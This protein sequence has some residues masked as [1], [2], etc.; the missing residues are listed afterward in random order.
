MTALRSICELLMDVLLQFLKAESV[1]PQLFLVFMAF[2]THRLTD[3]VYGVS[4]VVQGGPLGQNGSF[5]DLL[6]QLISDK[7]AL[8]CESQPRLQL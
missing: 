1:R 6:Q 4:F 8:E 2:Q 5:L 7:A 3:V